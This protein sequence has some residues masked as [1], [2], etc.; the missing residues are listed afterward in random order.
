[1]AGLIRV[2]PAELYEMAQRYSNEGGQVNEQIT[3][4]DGMIQHLLGVWEGASSEAFAAQ[5]EELKPS[6]IK[7]AELLQDVSIQL[8]SAG[9]VLEDTDQQIASQIRG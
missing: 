1:M 5:Y 6:F 2:T 7:M 3:R 4:L 9:K 8:N